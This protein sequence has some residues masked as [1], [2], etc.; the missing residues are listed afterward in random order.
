MSINN[1]KNTGVNLTPFKTFV[2]PLKK[3]IKNTLNISK[4]NILVIKINNLVKNTYQ[5]IR[6]YI[7]YCYFNN[8]EYEI[9]PEF[10]KMSIGI[11]GICNKNKPY[12]NQELLSKINWYYQ[13]E[14][15]PIYS[16]CKIN[17][18][19]LSH[20]ISDIIIEIETCIKNNIQEH[21]IQ[22]FLRFINKTTIN[23]T[24]DK[25]LLHCFKK[26]LL[27]LN[28]NN[29]S[30]FDQW[31]Q[32]HLHRILYFQIDKNK[33]KT[34]NYDIKVNPL[35]YLNGMMYMNLFL[36]SFGFKTFQIIP[37]RTSNIPKQ[38]LICG[39]SLVDYFE[40]VYD[41][42]K[43]THIMTKINENQYY[44]WNNFLDFNHKIFKSKNYQFAFKIRTDGIS[45]GLIFVRK[46]LIN[47]KR[48]SLEFKPNEEKFYRYIEELSEK[49]LLHIKENFNI[50]GC[51]PGKRNLV[52][53]IDS[54]GNKLSFTSVQRQF[55][56]KT[57]RCKEIIEKERKLL[58]IEN[59]ESKLSILNSKTMNYNNYKVYI[60]DKNLIDNLTT[61]F[62]QH[63]THRKMRLRRFIYGKKSIDTFIS[64][65]GKTFDKNCII[66]YGDWS[67]NDQMKYFEPTLGKG[68]RTLIHRK[69]HTISINEAYS[70]KNCHV[71][72]NEMRNY[73]FD[74][75][76]V[77]KKFSN[78]GKNKKKK[79]HHKN[80]D[81]IR[82]L[83]VCS[84]CSPKF[85]NVFKYVSHEDKH[86]IFRNRDKNGAI[87]IM[88][89]AKYYIKY[90]D[91][92]IKFC[93]N[94]YSSPSIVRVS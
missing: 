10:I 91:R 90:K 20:F 94:L 30:I 18:V 41:G 61:S 6:G 37:Q 87:N 36:E 12:K 23:I 28:F 42:K 43:K 34:I 93:H 19:G 26:E 67:R 86:T 35:K 84:N 45:C 13:N 24:Q 79:L 80:G 52:S 44:C 72:F 29:N 27:E 22:H 32:V 7:L 66:A 15:Q 89:L 2:I 70:S 4:I 83:L 31:K 88:N 81:K 68:L 21:F 9:T 62:Y 64:K 74:S 48:G 76:G 8:I 59:L 47:E 5:F 69:Y 78:R 57:I 82:G 1:Y 85:P 14:F 11:L 54:K 17:L 55:E 75:S 16:H 60:R 50:V 77:E 38:I 53:M 92:P 56:N 49:E 65:I 25:S 71:C 39:S 3:I 58:G 46:D 63:E 51:D 33:M 40:E 73:I